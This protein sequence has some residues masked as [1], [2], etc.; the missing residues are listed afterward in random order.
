MGSPQ[1]KNAGANPFVNRTPYDN[2]PIHHGGVSTV[3]RTAS[4]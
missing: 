3:A 1:Q 2:A 4:S